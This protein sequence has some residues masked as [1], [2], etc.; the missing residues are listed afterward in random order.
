MTVLLWVPLHID[1]VVGEWGL[2]VA[3]R[4]LGS[5]HLV[6]SAPQ[7]APH[8]VHLDLDPVIVFKEKCLVLPIK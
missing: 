8:L 3:P 6:R 2:R 4:E 7:P 5:G 1:G